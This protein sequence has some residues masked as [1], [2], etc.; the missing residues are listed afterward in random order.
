MNRSHGEFAI[1]ALDRS[2]CVNAPKDGPSYPDAA[3]FPPGGLRKHFRF[4]KYRDSLACRRRG[5][6]EL[7]GS[8]GHRRVG[9]DKQ[10]VEECQSPMLTLEFA[11]VVFAQLED[12]LALFDGAARG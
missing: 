5:H 10:L 8:A 7:P 12:R 1:G 11:P 3:P 9:I 4:H 2:W 6:A